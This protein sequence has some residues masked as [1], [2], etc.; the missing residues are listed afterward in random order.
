MAIGRALSVA[1]SFLSCRTLFLAHCCAIP[2]RSLFRAAFLIGRLILARR[3]Y[4]PRPIHLS[5]FAAPFSQQAL[6]IYS[7]ASAPLGKNGASVCRPVKNGE[8]SPRKTIAEK[9][10]TVFERTSRRHDRERAPESFDC[11]PPEQF[12]LLF[13]TLF[14]IQPLLFGPVVSHHR[15]YLFVTQLKKKE[16]ERELA[17]LSTATFIHVIEVVKKKV[18]EIDRIRMARLLNRGK[19]AARSDVR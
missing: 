15:S 16:E 11:A 1:L 8:A 14:I 18:K 12:F 13:I 17:H 4:C 5:C 6:I 2:T 10:R 3:R 9:R 7:A 19:L